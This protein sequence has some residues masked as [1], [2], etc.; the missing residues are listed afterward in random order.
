MMEALLAGVTN[1]CEPVLQSV[2]LYGDYRMDRLPPS[3]PSYVAHLN[4]AGQ[5]DQPSKMTHVVHNIGRY[6]HLAVEFLVCSNAL[7]GVAF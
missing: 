4:V 1:A 7:V 3:S 5:H 2:L 6:I